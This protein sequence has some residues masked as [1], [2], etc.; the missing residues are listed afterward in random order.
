MRIV[1]LANF[2]TPTSGGI[3]VSLAALRA[4]YHRAGHRVDLIVPGA[5]DDSVDIPGGRMYTLRADRIPGVGGYRVITS[6]GAVRRLLEELTPDTVE[7]S[8]RTTL[9]GVGAWARRA[10]VRAVLMAHERLDVQLAANLPRALPTRRIADRLN[11][12]AMERFDAVVTTSRFG[13]RE[14]TR[15]GAGRVELIPLGVDLETFRRS[16]PATGDGPP[17]LSYAGRMSVDKRPDLA[18]EALRTLN[19]WGI[20]AR[21]QMIG[22]G[23][24][25]EQL[26]SQARGLPVEFHGF[27]AEAA[28]VARLLADSSVAVAPCAGEC[29]GLAALEALACGVPTVVAANSGAAELLTVPGSGLS[30][31]PGHRA[32]AAAAREILAWPPEERSWAARRAAEGFPWSE[33]V[34]GMLAVHGE[35]TPVA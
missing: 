27:V 9:L 24:M 21:L 16:A 8:D 4:G 29:F 34:K 15:V 7:V 10:G 25:L 28:G 35:R 22:T 12:A 33:A 3:R 18:I 2:H 11:R 20:E 13:S 32:I 17:L 6:L 19:R 5:S 30:V 1:Q 14:W 23:P 26:R 31:P